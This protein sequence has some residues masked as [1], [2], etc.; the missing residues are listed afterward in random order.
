MANPANYVVFYFLH[1]W[2]ENYCFD[3]GYRQDLETLLLI[4]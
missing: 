1:S 3:M 2:A 4:D